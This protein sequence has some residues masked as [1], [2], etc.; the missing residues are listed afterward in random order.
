[1]LSILRHSYLM[2]IFDVKKMLAFQDILGTPRIIYLLNF[3]CLAEFCWKAYYLVL[4]QFIG[5]MVN[6]T[7]QPNK[8]SSIS[9][10][11]QRLSTGLA[12]T[13]PIVYLSRG[14]GQTAQ[15]VFLKG[16][17]E[18]QRKLADISHRIAGPIVLK[19][20]HELLVQKEKSKSGLFVGGEGLGYPRISHSARIQPK[21]G[22]ARLRQK[23][24][25]IQ[26]SKVQGGMS[27]KPASKK[28]TKTS[29]LPGGRGLGAQ[30]QYIKVVQYGIPSAARLLKQPDVYEFKAV[31]G[32]SSQRASPKVILK[33]RNL[34]GG[35]NLGVKS[36]DLESFIGSRIQG[37]AGLL[38]NSHKSS[39]NSPLKIGVAQ[40]GSSLKARQASL[41]ELFQII[42]ADV[43]H[44]SFGSVTVGRRVYESYIRF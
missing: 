3:S 13:G 18:A 5:K 19:L 21:Q 27:Q 16:G 37:G 43:P 42:S 41:A 22:G 6:D 34:P 32:G 9:A 14:V 7:F 23:P 36:I 28:T 44:S 20:H 39:K 31:Q 24:V 26:V 2:L 10:A 17:L 35:A 25:N 1:M 29:S 12:A 38:L 15:Q 4:R 33:R 11:A 40:G 8:F 30:K